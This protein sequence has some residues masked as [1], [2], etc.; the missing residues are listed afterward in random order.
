MYLV[1]SFACLSALLTMLFGAEA[2]SMTF[3]CSNPPARVWGEYHMISASTSDFSEL[4]VVVFG[5]VEGSTE[6]EEEEPVATVEEFVSKPNV[7]AKASSSQWKNATPFDLTTEDLGPATIY[8][9]TNEFAAESG[10]SIA[11]LKIGGKDLRLP[12]RYSRN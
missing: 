9:H 5:L 10:E 8:L 6:A 1:K 2:L 7:A 11:R 3:V 12:C 4:Q